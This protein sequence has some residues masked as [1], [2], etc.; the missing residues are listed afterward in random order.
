MVLGRSAPCPIGRK[1]FAMRRAMFRT[2]MTALPLLIAGLA[3]ADQP[4]PGTEVLP[5]PPTVAPDQAAGATAEPPPPPAEP[6]P[7]PYSIPWQLRPAAAVNVVRSDTSTGFRSVNG[8]G[9]TTVATLLLASYKVTPDLA[10]VVR[11]GFV[12]DAPPG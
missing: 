11:G 10:V 12:D 4:M 8:V 1:I 5:A 3:R 7:P 6:T 9:G 2:C